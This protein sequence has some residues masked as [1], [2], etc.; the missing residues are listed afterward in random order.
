MGLDAL[1]I[2]VIVFH[3]EYPL[4]DVYSQIQKLCPRILLYP[5]ALMKKKPKMQNR[6]AL[7]SIKLGQTLVQVS[8]HPISSLRRVKDFNLL[9]K[10]SLLFIFY[11]FR[12]L[13]THLTFNSSK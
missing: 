3:R 10:N 1:V 12:F 11:S 5:L 13:N 9:R 8:R 6:V 2:I 4:K 7:G